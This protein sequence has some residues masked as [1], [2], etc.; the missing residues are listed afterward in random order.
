MP[1][2]RDGIP[3]R[4][5]GESGLTLV[6][7]MVAAIVLG[8]SV[9]G[10]MSMLGIGVGLETEGILRQQA[11]RIAANALERNAFHYSSW[12][13]SLG[14]RPDQ[15]AFLAT[16]NGDTIIGSLKVSVSPDTII[17]RDAL[18]PDD[19]VKVP[20]VTIASSVIWDLSGELDTVALSKSITEFPL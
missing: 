7:L 10:V 18:D 15:D 16:V 19:S 9:T 6:E 3:S 14:S 20:I 12:P 1:P 4:A 2:P 5:R 11:R 8:V 17:C 13:I